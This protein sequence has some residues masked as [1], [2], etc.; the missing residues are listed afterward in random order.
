MRLIILAFCS[1][2]ATVALAQDAPPAVPTPGWLDSD[3][4]GRHD[5]YR[6]ADG[7]GVNDASGLPYAHRFA[8]L[9]DDGDR[10]NDLWRDADGDGVNDLETSFRDRDGDGRDDNVLD[11]DA[12]GANDVTGRAYGRNDLHGEQFGFV[13]DGLAW[14][15]EDG[16]GFADDAAGAAGG[17]RGRQD[18]FIDSDGDGMADDCWFEDGGFR[19]HRARSGQGGG[20]GGPGGPGGGGNQWRGGGSPVYWSAQ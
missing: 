15:D 13:V 4:D 7:D 14:V 3:G 6:D 1:F 8:W 2:V 19:H 9:D 11:E 16:D 5:L 17:R 10:A 12:D 20:A 18:R